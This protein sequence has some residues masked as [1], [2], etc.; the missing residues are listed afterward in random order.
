MIFVR[1]PFHGAIEFY[2]IYFSHGALI[3]V[4]CF[5]DDGL[6]TALCAM[7]SGLLAVYFRVA[8]CFG[9]DIVTLM[10]GI[11]FALRACC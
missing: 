3:R 4:D 6:V 7:K 11:S 9:L 1:F 5:R 8:C 10:D 2:F